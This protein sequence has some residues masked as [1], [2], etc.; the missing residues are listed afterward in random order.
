MARPVAGPAVIVARGPD[1]DRSA[2]CVNG[3]GGAPFVFAAAG[4]RTRR[5]I[6]NLARNKTRSGRPAGHQRRFARRGASIR[7]RARCLRAAD[8]GRAVVIRALRCGAWTRRRG[9]GLSVGLWPPSRWSP[10]VQR[11]V[12]SI[13]DAMHILRR[14]RRR[15][16]QCSLVRSHRSSPRRDSRRRP[17]GAEK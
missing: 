1:R 14:R 15:R 10:S 6:K 7:S 17:S 12:R 3:G 11:F 8:G 5:V 2:S 13:N 16:C 9:A 4:G